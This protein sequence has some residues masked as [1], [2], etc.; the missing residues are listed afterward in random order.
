MSLS[1]FLGLCAA[2]CP[3]TKDPI[4]ASAALVQALQPIVARNL[5]TLDAGVVSVTYIHAGHTNNVIPNS[6][7]RSRRAMNVLSI[8]VKSLSEYGIEGMGVGEP[9][10]CAFTLCVCSCRQSTCYMYT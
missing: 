7:R 1:I 8:K 6:V 2:R 9:C 4:V 5:D 3:Q 10:A